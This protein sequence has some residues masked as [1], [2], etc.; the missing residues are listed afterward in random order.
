MSKNIS[1]LSKKRLVLQLILNFLSPFFSLLVAIKNF[2]NYSFQIIFLVF[3]FY[4][5]TINVVDASDMV[6]YFDEFKVVS[7]WSFSDLIIFYTS[8]RTSDFY[9]QTLGY[10]VSNFTT[11]VRVYMLVATGVYSV[12]YIGLVKKMYNTA[13]FRN[14]KLL[15]LVL[16]VLFL[17]VPIFYINGL[18]FYTAFYVYLFSVLQI[19]IYKNNRFYLL[20]FLSP[21]IHSAFLLSVVI[22]M[23]FLLVGKIRVICIF[24]LVLSFFSSVTQFADVAVG[25]TENLNFSEKIN[26]YGSE[27]G[28]ERLLEQD[29]EVHKN[30]SSLY[31][32]YKTILSSSYY[33]SAIAMALVF[34]N[35]KLR[36]LFD[37]FSSTLLNFNILLLS[38]STFSST[39]IEGYRFQNIYVLFWFCSL[40]IVFSANNLNL[41][42]NRILIFLT[43]ALLIHSISNF[44]IYF[45]TISVE[46]LVSNWISYWLLY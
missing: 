30:A 17:Y 46:F 15:R 10:L 19:V 5:Y 31:Y 1:E 27:N 32:I 28:I 18:R 13:D 22:L 38:L 39:F 36:S 14:E 20:A 2:N 6:R 29:A 9:T 45:G 43:I 25:L 35:T 37:T 21:L 33:I 42:L 16:L 26:S 41:K 8:L 4:G 3:C 34:F 24:I 40:I 12:F 44:Y 23:L 11:D 7:Q